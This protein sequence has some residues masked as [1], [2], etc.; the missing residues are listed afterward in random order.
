MFDVVDTGNEA[1]LQ[2]TKVDVQWQAGQVSDE[3][4]L[5]ALRTYANSFDANTADWYR[6]QERVR[7]AQYNISRD[8][9][10]GQIN[11]G[12]KTLADLLEFDAQAMANIEPTNQEYR[13][14][15]ERLRQT[16]NQVAYDAFDKVR[17]Q[18]Q[19]GKVTDESYLAAFTT[20]VGKLTDPED[21]ESARLQLEATRYTLARNALVTRINKGN[22]QVGDLL[23]FDQQ[24]LL[25]GV[26]PGS[27]EYRSRLG[28][29]QETQRAVFS[30]Q[31]NEVND[32]WSRGQ[33]TTAQLLRWYEEAAGGN[34]ASGNAQL[35]DQIAN[36]VDSLQI[37]VRDERD[38]KIVDDFNNGR[39]SANA[40]LAYAR[41]ARDRYLPNTPDYRS[42]SDRIDDATKRTV[43]DNLLYRYDL[44]KQYAD[45]KR[46]VQTHKKAPWAGGA[47][48]E[49]TRWTLDDQNNW[50]PHVETRTTPYTPTQDQLDS[51][52]E[53][54]A[55]VAES[56]N[57]MRY[58]EGQI[59]T[60]PG[61]WVD[62]QHLLGYY[63]GI[64]RDYV[65][66]SSEWYQ[67][68]QRIDSVHEAISQDNVYRTIG[69]TVT[70][71]WTPRDPQVVGGGQQPGGN[72]RPGPN[73][74]GDNANVPHG[75]NRY[76]PLGYGTQPYTDPR[77]GNTYVNRPTRHGAGSTPSG[78]GIT[79]DD[80]LRAL[81]DHESNN[82]YTARNSTTG[83]YGKYQ[84]LP[85]Y[86][87]SRAKRW[88][89]NANAPMTPE[90]QEKVTRGMVQK[91]YD[92]WGDWRFVALAW[93][94]GH[95]SS[96]DPN[97]W[98][99]KNQ[100]YV[101]RT[102]IRLGSD[103][104]TPTTVQGLYLPDDYT[105]GGGTAPRPQ[106]QPGRGGQQS[107]V[108]TPPTPTA[109][110]GRTERPGV[111]PPTS[112]PN[113][114]TSGSAFLRQYQ[115]GRVV[116]T[117]LPTWAT[118]NPM[119]GSNFESFYRDFQ[120][121]YASGATTV[122]IH[123]PGGGTVTYSLPARAEARQAMMAQLDAIR[124]DFHRN[125]SAAYS[126]AGDTD[127][128]RIVDSLY[129]DAVHQQGENLLI[130]MD[131]LE[132]APQP[133]GGPSYTGQ[134][135]GG[136]N[137]LA[138]ASAYITSTQ[139]YID[140]NAKLA[141]DAFDRGDYGAALAFTQR[142]QQRY[143]QAGPTLNRFLAKAEGQATYIQSQTGADIPASVQNSLEKL[144]TWNTQID[145]SA[146]ED[147][148]TQM[149]GDGKGRRGFLQVDMVNGQPRP[150]LDPLTGAPIMRSDYVPVL[151]DNGKVVAKPQDPLALG[152][153]GKPLPGQT[154]KAGVPVTVRTGNTVTTAY[155]NAEEDV[156]GTF[157][158]GTP[159]YGRRM[160]D[161][162]GNHFVYENPFDPGH[163]STSLI[164]YTLP[165]GARVTR[166]PSK[167]TDL[168]ASVIRFQG[169]DGVQYTMMPTGDGT[170]QYL[171]GQWDGPNNTW[172]DGTTFTSAATDRRLV[173]LMQSANFTRDVSFIS[174]SDRA[175]ADT[176]GAVIG[177]SSA[178][179]LTW[180]NRNAPPAGLP[181][182]RAT[183][184]E[185]E[186]LMASL[187]PRP[188]AT[189]TTPPLQ[190]SGRWGTPVTSYANP[191]AQ[192]RSRVAPPVVKPPPV[193]A[194]LGTILDPNELRQDQLATRRER[195]TRKV[196][197]PRTRTM[198]LPRKPL[199]RIMPPPT[200]R[201]G[202]VQRRVD[203]QDK[204][205]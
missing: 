24:A 90:N 188:F 109:G 39:M 86:W 7:E 194:P 155:R 172:V 177:M 34:L 113:R 141:Q 26:V 22:A 190:S 165:T 76:S 143:D 115:N 99:L 110:G 119:T 6:A 149:I 101:N 71:P 139:Q 142:A 30:E 19:A 16:T 21:H 46:F 161:P 136:P 180:I 189:S 117:A 199:P 160:W 82:N 1:Y 93:H 168:K 77:T 164:N 132:N 64:Q 181:A 162:V 87:P 5:A 108:G 3:A 97:D 74:R 174:P 196:P 62:N 191:D 14:R 114:P 66:G 103:M 192:E 18:W 178:E 159:I 130:G 54:Q 91:L 13:T 27:D 37:R 200:G 12:T 75:G 134:T 10:V 148:A 138:D 203:L 8:Q 152:P 42:W 118:D 15:Q 198:P 112:T 131:Q 158:D 166:N 11:A 183:R 36:K 195:R 63:Q 145:V 127:A 176:S 81:G 128:A 205:Y 185:D 38:S 133:S 156:V 57:Q 53:I 45:L 23:A 171:I 167:P 92:R 59:S 85:E 124:I 111:A 184:G 94:L 41:E 104:W 135:L 88:L 96:T 98:N 144:R 202:A 121:G 4:Y 129:N 102:M 58:I 56:K 40:F 44:T 125:R 147:L 48:S 51:W 150:K 84:H 50:V 100:K 122:T 61:G 9:L 49:E 175:L 106:P 43:E 70:Y 157:S 186:G 47:T 204:G 126:A 179:Y 120:S 60:V 105:A 201:A 29:L 32:R 123:K 68:Q 153:D 72:R 17:E 154:V 78:R 25:A 193:V 182:S 65:A 137:P 67:I 197:T 140:Q 169:A 69:V 2:F 31:E 173:S 52:A 163:W 187:V 116:Q 73:Q 95:V 28:R 79:V 80:F 20:Y 83:A 146:I 170:G 89:G 151:D 55:Q 107:R 33:M 35:L